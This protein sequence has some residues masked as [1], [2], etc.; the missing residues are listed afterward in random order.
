MVSVYLVGIYKYGN[1]IQYFWQNSSYTRIVY[2]YIIYIQFSIKYE[3]IYTSIRVVPTSVSNFVTSK[4]IKWQNYEQVKMS[5]RNRRSSTKIQPKSP[6]PPITAATKEANIPSWVVQ[7]LAIHFEKDPEQISASILKDKT[8]LQTLLTDLK[9]DNNFND[10]NIMPPSIEGINKS[11]R[12]LNKK[13]GISSRSPVIKKREEFPQ[14]PKR[15][16]HAPALVASVIDSRHTSRGPVNNSN[17]HYSAQQQQQ[18]KK[19]EAIQ[20]YLY[21]SSEEDSDPATSGESD[22]EPTTGKEFHQTKKFIASKKLRQVYQEACYKRSATTSARV[23][24]LLQSRARLMNISNYNLGPN[25]TSA[26]ADTLLYA[27]ENGNTHWVGSLYASGNNCGDQGAIALASMIPKSQA[28]EH[29][30]VD[31]NNLRKDAGVS[32]A[33]ALSRARP[34]VSF[35][36]AGNPVGFGSALLNELADSD[37]ILSKISRINLNDTG[38][39]EV[40]SNTLSLVARRLRKQLLDIQ[41]GWNYIQDQTFHMLMRTLLHITE[42]DNE[43]D[44]IAVS[45]KQE[46]GEY[47]GQENDGQEQGEEQDDAHIK[48]QKNARQNKMDTVKNNFGGREGKGGGSEKQHKQ[49]FKSANDVEKQQNENFINTTSLLSS[50]KIHSFIRRLSFNMCGLSDSAGIFMGEILKYSNSIHYLDISSN[51]FGQ[52]TAIALSSGL[53]MNNSLQILN[54]SFNGLEIEGTQYIVSA[55]GNNKSLRELWL[56]NTCWKNEGRVDTKPV[57]KPRDIDKGNNKKQKQKS[58]KKVQK[59][60]QNK[61]KSKKQAIESLSIEERFPNWR[62]AIPCDQDTPS[63]LEKFEGLKAKALTIIQMR[64]EYLMLS[65]M[66]PHEPG[67]LSLIG[68]DKIESE[69]SSSDSEDDADTKL[70]LHD[71][72]EEYRSAFTWRSLETDSQGYFDTKRIMKRAFESDWAH[73]HM[74]RMCGNSSDAESVRKILTKHYRFLHELFRYESAQEDVGNDLRVTLNGWCLLIKKLSLGSASKTLAVKESDVQDI[75]YQSVVKGSDNHINHGKKGSRTK[76]D[77]AGPGLWRF[78]FIEAIVRL[79]NLRRRNKESLSGS[80]KMLIE[81]VLIQKLFQ[82]S[83]VGT[84]PGREFYLD[85]RHFRETRLYCIQVSQAFLAEEDKLRR[86]YKAYAKG[87]GDFSFHS[88]FKMSMREWS[89]FC[90]ASGF[91]FRRYGLREVDHRLAFVYSQPAKIDPLKS[92]GEAVTAGQDKATLAQLSYT[93]FL[94]ALGR[95]ACMLRHEHYPEHGA[96]LSSR[97]RR[98]VRDV[99]HTN[100]V[101]I[102]RELEDDAHLARDMARENILR[103]EEEK[104][105]ER[106]HPAPDRGKIEDKEYKYGALDSKK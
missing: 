2:K 24:F 71:D 30:I 18:Q 56:Q 92:R 48:Q 78:Q 69:E 96:K 38:I 52:P 41:L 106:N 15:F 42:E 43:Q 98:L 44:D 85:A 19:K 25:G 14:F 58:R 33:R 65:L 80:I 59:N 8:L 76:D 5:R 73:S 9:I 82:P 29:I 75:F 12:P 21:F 45:E 83:H 47:D 7:K 3:Y 39:T 10:T 32:F 22:N 35:S 95:I 97:I 17:M 60:I 88:D 91:T 51:Y 27:A 49:V 46:D 13:S 67:M 100:R 81:G 87:D 11:K 74:E 89:Q 66:Y 99:L 93:D 63:H 34:L 105:L 20:N 28:L 1:K 6:P 54:V 94:E 37:I 64:E 40:D 90:Q 53:E 68:T 31:K 101:L 4:F 62:P 79:A 16:Y 50:F 57:S 55:C 72:D 104:R 70:T 86:L 102:K 26:L 84:A 36:A 23:I 77:E 103:I 61:K